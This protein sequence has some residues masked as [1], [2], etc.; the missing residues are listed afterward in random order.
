M[1][2]KNAQFFIKHEET[3]LKARALLITHL[4]NKPLNLSFNNI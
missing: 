4:H 1:A 2:V 3:A